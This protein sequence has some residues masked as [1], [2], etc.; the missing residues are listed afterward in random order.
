MWFFLNKKSG[1]L[2]L[3]LENLNEPVPE[4][5]S[6]ETGIKFE[7]TV[8]ALEALDKLGFAHSWMEEG[9]RYFDLTPLGQALSEKLSDIESIFR[10]WPEGEKRSDLT[11]L[12][13]QNPLTR[14]V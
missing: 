6:S 7:E 12:R 10:R 9:E 2:V 14:G 8:D 5:V 1:K 4:Y 13:D 11:A 3:A